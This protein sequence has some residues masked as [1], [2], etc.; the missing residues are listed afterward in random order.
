MGMAGDGGGSGGAAGIG[1][2]GAGGAGGGAAGGGATGQAG[3]GG[4]AGG[5]GGASGNAG[6]SGGGA[7]GYAGMPTGGA[8]GTAGAPATTA[9]SC[10]F[11]GDF[12]GD[13]IKD[14]ARQ[15]GGS[16]TTK[17]DLWFNKGVSS[18]L[19][20]AATVVTPAVLPPGY[21]TADVFDVNHDARQDVILGVPDPYTASSPPGG[22]AFE[23]GLVT[24]NADGTFTEW[25]PAGGF[26]TNPPIY[27]LGPLWGA[28]MTGGIAAVGDFDGDGQPDVLKMSFQNTLY[29]DMHWIVI[30]SSGGSDFHVLGSNAIAS[31]RGAL[32]IE[33]VIDLN[34]DQKLDVV[35]LVSVSPTSGSNY[36]AYATGKGDGTFTSLVKVGGTDGA[37]QAS[38]TDADGDGTI[39]LVVTFASGSPKTFYGDGAGNFSTTAP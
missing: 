21:T 18:Q 30:K 17:A 36:V 9:L 2:A 28:R 29:T 7:G 3:S 25:M 10:T 16:S 39:D 6:M 27:G 8:A 20:L 13:G 22:S 12:D 33:S 32:I 38:A 23:V 24:G 14:C 26:P 5:A 19:Y 35:A 1:E 31:L 4:M 11:I 34:K 15:Q 37:T